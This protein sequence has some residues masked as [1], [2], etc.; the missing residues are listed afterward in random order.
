MEPLVK[1]LIGW[2]ILSIGY[3]IYNVYIDEG[4]ETK[5]IYVWRSFWIGTVSWIGIIFAIIF[6]IVGWVLVFNEWVEEKLS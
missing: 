3:Y 5:K 6:L 1:Y 2:L 4:P